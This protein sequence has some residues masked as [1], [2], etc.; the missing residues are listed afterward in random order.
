MYSEMEALAAAWSAGRRECL[1]SSFPGEGR[2]ALSPAH[3][4][5]VSGA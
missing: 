1:E 2:S 4:L 5:P 3:V